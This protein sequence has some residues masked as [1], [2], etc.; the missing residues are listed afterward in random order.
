MLLTYICNTGTLA[1]AG[2]LKINARREDMQCSLAHVMA[3]LR[4]GGA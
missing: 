1:F 2:L 3:F 4:K